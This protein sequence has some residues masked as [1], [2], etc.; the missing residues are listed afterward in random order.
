MK[1]TL[2]L[3]ACLALLS[4]GYEG[5]SPS[6]EAGA[7]PLLRFSRPLEGRVSALV[8]SHQETDFATDP[9]EDEEESDD[10]EAIETPSRLPGHLIGPPLCLPGACHGRGY[11]PQGTSP[12]LRC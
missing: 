4:P 9:S 6:T 3:L 7:I 12:P 1:P 5:A 11:R 2:I 10:P 8:P